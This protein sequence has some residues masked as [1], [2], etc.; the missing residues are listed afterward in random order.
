ME[1]L[2]YHK[3]ETKEKMLVNL[4]A[5]CVFMFLI[6]QALNRWVVPLMNPQIKNERLE[7]KIN[8]LL[9]RKEKLEIL[10]VEV[11]VT[12]RTVKWENEIKSL[13]NEILQLEKGMDN[14]E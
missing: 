8:K 11:E 6:Y 2:K 4:L 9:E 7:Q 13:E 12:N 5:V 1:V 14:N 10:Q 3:G